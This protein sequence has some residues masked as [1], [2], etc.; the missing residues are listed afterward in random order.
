MQHPL[1]T[2][3]LGQR[4]CDCGSGK[5]DLGHKKAGDTK[6]SKKSRHSSVCTQEQ[7]GTERLGIAESVIQYN[8]L[9]HIVSTNSQPQPQPPD[10]KLFD[11]VITFSLTAHH[12]SST[13]KL[14]RRG[15]QYI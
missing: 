2:L 11:C 13:Y 15:C 9:Y 8:P 5:S 6:P 7:K 14:I 3:N 4:L 1:L 12:V 10:V